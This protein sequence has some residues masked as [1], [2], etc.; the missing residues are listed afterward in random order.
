MWSVLTSVSQK[1]NNQVVFNFKSPEIPYFLFI[2]DQTPIVPQYIWSKVSNPS[3]YTDSNPV[4]TGGFVLQSCSPETMIFVKN[5]NY[6]QP[7]L[8]KVDKL[9]M[10]DFSA[11]GP[12]NSLLETG[13]AN[14]GGEFIPDITQLYIDKS[15]YYHSWQP[16]LGAQDLVINTT[17]PLLNNVKVRQA[18]VYALDLPHVA[19]IGE[20]GQVPAQS[21]TGLIVPLFSSWLD[22]PLVAKYDYHYD[23]AK[24]IS[25]LKSAGFKKNGSGVF[26]SPSGKPLSFTCV[27]TTGETNEIADLQIMTQEW[28]AVGIDV[29]PDILSSAAANSDAI[30]GHFQLSYEPPGGVQGP[31]PYYVLNEMLSSSLTAPIGKT[32]A[33]NFSRYSSPSTDSLLSAFSTASTATAQHAIID[34]LEGVMLQQVPVIPVVGNPNWYQYDT[35]Q[36]IGWPTPGDPYAQPGP[37]T[38]PDWGIVLLHLHS[39]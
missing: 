5:P 9:E 16:V 27:E 36:M 17:V 32:A 38:F 34:K 24:A 6:W 11:N 29:T 2:A 13:G 15:P 35:Q 37:S 3:T 26:V 8:P 22:K 23:P 1:G 10:P 39:R 25:I 20:N 12:S 19:A 14:W 4:G 31:T 30:L 7:G 33:T 21:Q 28:K 18:M